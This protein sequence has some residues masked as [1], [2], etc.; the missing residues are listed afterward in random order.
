MK[1]PK[2]MSTFVVIFLILFPFFIA[3]GFYYRL[4]VPR[5]IGEFLEN[6]ENKVYDFRIVHSLADEKKLQLLKKDIESEKDNKLAVGGQKF[7]PIFDQISAES[8]VSK[9][10][11]VIAIDEK[12]LNALDQWPIRR[13]YYGKLLQRVLEDG[14]AA[15]F[16]FDVVFAERGDPGLIEK[17]QELKQNSD[18]GFSSKIED[19]IHAVN[20]DAV[21]LNAVERYKRR[22]VGG[23]A[24]LTQTEAA[25]K[26]FSD[27]YFPRI[28]ENYDHS[29]LSDQAFRILPNTYGGTYNYPDLRYRLKFRGYFTFP[30]SSDG[31]LRNSNFLEVFSVKWMEEME[32]IE[33]AR[34]YGLDYKIENTVEYNNKK[35]GVFPEAKTLFGSLALETYLM[36][37]ASPIT[38]EA[39]PFIKLQRNNE[40][41]ILSE[42]ERYARKS[43]NDKGIEKIRQSLLNA[44]SLL[45]ENYTPLQKELLQKIIQKQTF[46]FDGNFAY[47]ITALNLYTNQAINEPDT[48][49][50]SFL[51][52]KERA[53]KKLFL[54]GL[55]E[56]LAE[57]ILNRFD[58]EWKQGV[59]EEHIKDTLKKEIGHLTENLHRNFT[60][61]LHKTLK[62]VLQCET[63]PLYS[64]AEDQG[65]KILN[66]LLNIALKNP[67][68]LK[69]HFNDELL[70]DF[71]ARVRMNRF[72]NG[73]ID[74]KA[75]AGAYIRYSMIDVLT[76]D[77]FSG[78]LFKFQTPEVSLRKALENKIIFFGPTALG[79]NDW[80]V[81]PVSKQI[82]GVETHAHLFDTLRTESAI[83]RTEGIDLLEK[84]LFII[85]AFAVPFFIR[86]LNA[87]YGAL[88][89]LFVFFMLYYLSSEYFIGAKE[90]F[91]PLMIKII[92]IFAGGLTFYY[93][94]KKKTKK[95]A[96]A[97]SLLL[98]LAFMAAFSQFEGHRLYLQI[99]PFFLLLISQY[100][101]L[102][103]YEFVQ[104]EK[105]RKKTRSAFQNYV[106]ASVVNAVLSDPE[107]LK[108]GGQ[109]REM[110]CL[111]SDVRG[112]TTISEKLE[113]QVLVSLMN[114]YLEEMTDLVMQYDG[115]LDK[116]IGDA[117][118]A[119]WGAPV[120]QKNH[121]ELAT[122]TAIE[123]NK[124]VAILYGKLL[125]KY[126]VEVR[127]GIG[128]NTG[129]MVV[130]NMGSKTRFNYTVL[131]DAVNLGARLEGQTKNY[132]AELILSQ[133]SYDLVKDWTAT[134]FLDLI[135]VKGKAEPVRIYECIGRKDETPEETLLGL[136]EFEQAVKRYYLGREFEEGIRVFEALKRYRKGK[137]AACDLYINRC[138]DFL[139][140]PPDESWNGVFVATSK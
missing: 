120:A 105:E 121:A 67:D 8:G 47:I 132:G 10:I 9:D 63:M 119:F 80:R 28:L 133:S 118:M 102:A 126:G 37:T 83:F 89:T 95:S 55:D 4:L 50:Q 125:E 129:P 61:N 93:L 56:K 108:L 59:S 53:Y 109:K 48:F 97:I 42:N 38:W 135:A 73:G 111:F 112:F 16:V 76:K 36:S 134:R 82:D 138:R 124:R 6:L 72:A 32:S 57:N 35:Y 136:H 91:S 137:D 39:P 24:T 31:V 71:R 26:N 75:G 98:I 62:F 17:L 3:D 51:R 49:I 113:P 68:F 139:E 117:V 70:Y 1:N 140:N 12:T 85:F 33:L 14:N 101:F 43:L 45:P 87:S 79:I 54:Q 66:E 21:L 30:Y 69:E 29:S 92:A 64:F 81:S 11:V 122:I 96:Y 13:D 94:K 20:Y 90:I 27:T 5:T 65:E 88:F 104:E 52:R 41:L 60:E 58:N 74:F 23:Y 110:T 22:I 130:G 103:T 128:I 77:R 127:I 7:T 78:E 116:F 115:T 44:L 131:G 25:I 107:M 34:S 18:T 114:E 84:L 123:M 106:N 86:R 46:R 100:T 15:G 99:V 19:L 2:P 40:W